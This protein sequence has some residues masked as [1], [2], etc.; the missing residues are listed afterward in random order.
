MFKQTFLT[1]RNRGPKIL[2]L[3]GIHGDETQAVKAVLKLAEEIS[4][5]VNS[6][7]SAL[8]KVTSYTFLHGVNDYGLL[9]HQRENTFQKET[10][11]SQ[12]LNRL[13]A[14]TYQTPQEVKDLITPEIEA[15]DIVIDVH[16]S[17]V[18]KNCFLVDYDSYAEKCLSLTKK[19][20][21][22]PL[23]RVANVGAGT[24]KSK[25]LSLG[26]I[27]FT[28]ELN[29]MGFL[30]SDTDQAATLLQDFLISIIESYEEPVTPLDNL[31]DYLSVFLYSKISGILEWKR[32]DPL[33]KKYGKGETI[34]T[35][36]SLDR[37]EVQEIKAPF[38]GGFV[39]DIPDSLY[40]SKGEPFIEYAKNPQELF[41]KV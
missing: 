14:P 31:A 13:F 6:L 21:L 3:S 4:K 12:N 36:T 29:G 5:S 18:C 35:V 11:P 20:A 8:S 2:V 23:L 25:A 19:T 22:A 28:V 7:A 1:T 24:V 17:P 41:N 39:Y 15:A 32:L 26:K 37:K 10:T 33:M 27:G 38:S 9:T 34:C 30:G 16:N 40:I